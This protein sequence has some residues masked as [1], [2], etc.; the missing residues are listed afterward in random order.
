MGV[1]KV[2]KCPDWKGGQVSSQTVL[3]LFAIAVAVL[4]VF[5]FRQTAEAACAQDAVQGCH[6]STK[7]ASWELKKD[8]FVMDWTILDSPFSLNCK[9]LV[10][11]IKK[12]RIIRAC[13]TEKLSEDAGSRVE[14]LR[15]VVMSQM[16]DCWYMYGEGSAKVQQAIDTDDDRTACLVCSEI[17]PDEEFR[18]E[19]PGIALPG[20]YKYAA[21]TG[22]PPKGEKTYLEYFLEGTEKGGIDV[23]KFDKDIKL[24]QPYSI[25]FAVS[26]QAERPTALFGSGGTIAPGAG[27]VDCYLG[28]YD[29]NP[30]RGSDALAIGC[31]EKDNVPFK[32]L[33]ESEN[34]GL[35]FGRVIDGGTNSELL[36]WK[37]WVPGFGSGFE[38]KRFPM[39]VRLV[40][41]KDLKNYC[42]R[43]Y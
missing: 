36:N 40:P 33:P 10:T 39:T 4:I 7:L 22:K 32:G 24:D 3:I 2:A 20:M 41:T 15:E 30:A 42:S 25:I 26:D 23:G 16:A 21:V 8:L 5:L 28:G 11:E 35:V 17:I 38:L 27:I 12:D 31:N 6:F 19:N 34:P 18:K 13:D 14:E 9:T 1:L 37:S 43:L 29:K